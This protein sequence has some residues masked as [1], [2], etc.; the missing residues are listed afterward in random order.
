[1][2]K[3]AQH[4]SAQDL[5]LLADGELPLRGTLRFRTHL[6][7]CWRCRARMAEIEATILDFVRAHAASYDSELQPIDGPRALLKARLA[8]LEQ[9]DRP[10]IMS[11]FRLALSQS[12]VV[13][14][15]LS[16]LLVLGL[17]WV[18]RQSQ[19]RE[20]AIRAGYDA[21]LPNPS[22]TPGA[23]K[24]V[25]LSEICSSEH[26]QVVRRVS[27]G[28]REAVFREYGIAGASASDYEIDHLVTPG[29]GGSD[30]IRN[31][32]PEPHYHAEWN[33]YVKDQLEDHLHHLVC[34]GQ[35]SLSTAQSDMESNWVVA[36]Q[37]YFNTD[38]PLLPYSS[39]GTIVGPLA[40]TL[41]KLSQSGLVL[42]FGAI[43]ALLFSKRRFVDLF[44]RARR[45]IWLRPTLCK[46]ELGALTCGRTV[47]K[48][49][50]S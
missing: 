16:I 4:P 49:H 39:S 8:Q 22:L 1:M 43:I 14:A 33:S 45:S 29:L 38:K 2:R 50:L 47:A 17:V 5:L 30:D 31:L 42:A 13:Y 18:C 34:T 46:K 26:D 35:V 9:P 20:R 11:W 3:E 21:A 40:R 7:S 32:W 10:G 36:Y 25:V 15:S 23:T 12:R 6:A 41:H 48:L 44:R 27:P 24:P 19:Q 37:R 28:I